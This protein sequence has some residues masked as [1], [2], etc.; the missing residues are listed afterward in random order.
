MPPARSGCCPDAVTTAAAAAAAA[1]SVEVGQI[2]NSLVVRRGRRSAARR[3]PPA[4]TGSTPA[5][6]PR[7]SGSAA[8]RAGRRPSSSARP[9]ARPSAASSPVGHPAPVRTLVD[10]RAG[11]SSTRSGRRAGSRTRCSRRRSTSWFASPAANRPTSPR[12]RR[13]ARTSGQASGRAGER[14]SA[15][16][17]AAPASAWARA[18]GSREGAGRRRY[19]PRG[20]GPL[21]ARHGRSHG[22]QVTGRPSSCTHVTAATPAVVWRHETSRFSASPSQLSSSSSRRSATWRGSAGTSSVTW[23]P[24]GTPT[25]PYES[26]QVLGLALTIGVLAGLLAADRAGVGRETC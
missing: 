12:P 15:H 6:S 9:P 2:A 25:G 4:R 5:R 7:C 22:T 26:W 11:A 3:S 24:P 21:R 13:P 16:T 1:R 14:A 17:L 18:G 19:G 8:V 23:T 10:T 20:A